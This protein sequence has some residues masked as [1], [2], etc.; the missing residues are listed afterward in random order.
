[1]KSI[2]KSQLKTA[3]KVI[4]SGPSTRWVKNQG[5]DLLEVEVPVV[6]SVAGKHPWS[7]QREWESDMT[8]WYDEDSNS[9]EIQNSYNDELDAE[10]IIEQVQNYMQEHFPGCVSV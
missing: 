2:S 1:M 6:L 9:Y 10:D 3:K 4:A 5:Y 7:S 8:V